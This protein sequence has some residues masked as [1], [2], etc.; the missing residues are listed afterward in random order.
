MF[1][2]N[3]DIVQNLLKLQHE[4]EQIKKHKHMQHTHYII[5]YGTVSMQVS[6]LWLH[7][8]I[9]IIVPIFP[10]SDYFCLPFLSLVLPS[11]TVKAEWNFYFQTQQLSCPFRFHSTLPSTLLCPIHPILLLLSLP[12]SLS[13]SHYL[14]ITTST[15]TLTCSF[16]RG[17]FEIAHHLV[18]SQPHAAHNKLHWS[19]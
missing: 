4:A 3:R 12:P 18:I 9:C 8:S 1:K 5:D 2:H 11:V 19:Y 10:Q 7:C 16:S 17:S 6:T 13:P 14:F 15:L